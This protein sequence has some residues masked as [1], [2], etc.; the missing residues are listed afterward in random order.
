MFK[1]LRKQVSDGIYAG[2]IFTIQIEL[3][4]LDIYFG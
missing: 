3:K 4:K 2:T 1:Q